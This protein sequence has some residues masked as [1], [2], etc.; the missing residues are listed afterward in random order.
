M[1]GVHQVI[2]AARA[3]NLTSDKRQARVPAGGYHRQDRS[4]AYGSIRRRRYYSAKAVDGLRT[5]SVDPYV[6][7]ERTP[8]GRVP[9]PAP[10]GRM[11]SHLPRGLDAAESADQAGPGIPEVPAQGPREREPG[12]AAH[13]HRPQPAQAVPLR[14]TPR[15]QKGCQSTKDAYFVRSHA[16]GP[17]TDAGLRVQLTAITVSAVRSWPK[18]HPLAIPLTGC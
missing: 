6:A 14:G 18:P 15:R 5:L 8:H 3:T 7:P 12:M 9:S 4:G 16:Y 10:R 13:L 2:V 17:D 11:P 1:D